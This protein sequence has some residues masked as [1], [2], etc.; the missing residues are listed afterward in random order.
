MHPSCPGGCRGHAGEVEGEG[1]RSAGQSGWGWRCAALRWG[2]TGA[3]RCAQHAIL[4]HPLA[5]CERT[6]LVSVSDRPACPHGR[7]AGGSRRGQGF[8]GA[9]SS[10]HRGLRSTIL[11]TQPEVQGAHLTW[12]DRLE[13]TRKASWAKTV[14]VRSG[15]GTL[16]EIAPGTH[17]PSPSPRPP[18]QSHPPPWVSG[19]EGRYTGTGL[20]GLT[21]GQHLP[22]RPRHG[23]CTHGSPNPEGRWHRCSLTR[24]SQLPERKDRRPRRQRHQSWLSAGPSAG[25]QTQRSLYSRPTPLAPCPHGQRP[26]A[27]E[28][29]RQETSRSSCQPLGRPGTASRAL[30]PEETSLRSAPG[31]E[32]RACHS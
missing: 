2:V 20:E 27:A 19:E 32:H 4:A 26:A 10:G 15:A 23:L 16:A 6:P 29:H 3:Q 30:S 21:D 17:T 1:P 7:A 12:A 8:R 5:I 28:K 31:L 11:S 13:T 9:C 18:G 14:G 22:P 24:Q 25:Q